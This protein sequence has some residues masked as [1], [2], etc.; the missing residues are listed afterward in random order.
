MKGGWLPKSL[1]RSEKVGKAE[2]YLGHLIGPLG[3]GFLSIM[4][5]S[6]LNVY[7]TDVCGL[8]RLWGGAFMSVYPILV[9]SL[10]IVTYILAGWLVDRTV[11]KQGKARPYLL[12][13]ALLLPV[14]ALFLFLVPEGNS[15]LTAGAVLTS[16]I[17]FFAVVATLYGTANTLMVPLTS[18]DVKERSQLAVVVNAQGL[19]TGMTVT[20]IFPT[21]I[22]PCIGIDQGKWITVMVITAGV[23]VPLLVLQYLF[24]RERVTEREQ[25][26]QKREEV[27]PGLREQLRCCRK[28]SMWVTLMAYFALLGLANALS[29]AAV[30]YYCNWV[31]GTYNDGITQVMFYAI[32]NLPM[33]IGVFLCNPICKKLGRTRA[34]VGGLILSCIGLGVCLLFPRNLPVVLAGQFIKA[35]GT[36]PSGYLAS[37]LLGEALDDVEKKS[38][39]RCD[40]FTSS[41]YNS[42]LTITNGIAIS[43]LNAGMAVFQYAAPSAGKVA[44]QPQGVQVFFVFCE[45]AVPLLAYPVLAYLLRGLG[46]ENPRR[47]VSRSH[48]VGVV[49]PSR[50]GRKQ[51]C[52][53]TSL[54][55]L[56]KD[57]ACQMRRCKAK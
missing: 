44:V 51:I 48:D 39:A 22:L 2:R 3:F 20:V 27:R 29:S 1:C 57:N 7:Y 56:T 40:G 11:T 13:S 9:K 36:I 8:G 10:D 30:F 28:S 5:N 23:A 15:V 33:G 50:E 32:G 26:E 45:M 55:D 43:V 54:K 14:S 31:L 21:V 6:Y 35:C 41:L 53:K 19:I 46:K 34:M 52:T 16:N 24:T 49:C 42:L 4:V 18:T 37:V 17:F 25:A 12:M 38:G 47:P